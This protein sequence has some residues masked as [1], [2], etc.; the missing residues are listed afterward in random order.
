MESVKV[1]IPDEIKRAFRVEDKEIWWCYWTPSGDEAMVGYCTPQG[2]FESDSDWTAYLALLDRN[3]HLREYPLGSSD[4]EPE[5]VLLYK[6]G[7]TFIAS[8]K[9]LFEK[10]LRACE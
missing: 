10:G 6:N 1:V 3:P 4:E 8:F 5:A 7:E 9:E 2:W